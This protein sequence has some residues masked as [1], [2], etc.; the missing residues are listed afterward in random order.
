MVAVTECGFALKYVPDKIM[1]HEICMAAVTQSG[2][3]L[4]FVP[5]ALR[6]HEICMAAVNACGYA[7]MYIPLSLR[8]PEICLAAVTWHDTAIG[9]VPGLY[10]IAKLFA[11]ARPDF[12]GHFDNLNDEQY[13]NI[14]DINPRIVCYFQHHAIILQSVL[15]T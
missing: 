7:L 11:V 12:M 2:V 3:A 10:S 13:M 1:N 9:S 4:K 14:V 5:V 15:R 8:T 6:T